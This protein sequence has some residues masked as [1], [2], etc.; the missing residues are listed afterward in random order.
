MT[1]TVRLEPHERQMAD[2][3]LM[4]WALSPDENI[5]FDALAL[6]DEFRITEALPTL[7]I[8]ASRLA[9]SQTPSAPYELKKV[10]RITRNLQHGHL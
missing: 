9:V 8:L 2:K 6:I 10:E 4:E 3:V 7:Q 1:F 5:R